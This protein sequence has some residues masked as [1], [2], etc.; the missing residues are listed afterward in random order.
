MKKSVLIFY[1][2]GII[3]VFAGCSN[4]LDEK[5]VLEESRQNYSSDETKTENEIVETVVPTHLESVAFGTYKMGVNGGYEKQNAKDNIQNINNIAVSAK[6]EN[7]WVVLKLVSKV[8]EGCVSFKLEKQTKFIAKEVLAARQT[9]YY[10][11]AIASLDGKAT[12]KGQIVST[13]NL[14]TTKNKTIIDIS[15]QELILTPGTYKLGAI[16]SRDNTKLSELI[17]LEIN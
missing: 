16:S 1:A 7:D 9:K 10:G 12:C 14:P 13:E 3:A 17:F 15:N 6:I 2:V 5:L 8:Q 4:G 11:I